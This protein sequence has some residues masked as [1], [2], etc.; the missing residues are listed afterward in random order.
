MRARSY[1]QAHIHAETGISSNT[2][3]IFGVKNVSSSVIKVE[4]NQGR[5]SET[6]KHASLNTELLP[7]KN[8]T[9]QGRLIMC[10]NH[11]TLSYQ[12]NG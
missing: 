10:V 3:V 7:L 12:N 11:Q 1:I 2:A 8:M 6:R 4:V 9:T 5:E